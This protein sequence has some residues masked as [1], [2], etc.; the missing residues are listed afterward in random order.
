LVKCLAKA[1]ALRPALKGD[2]RLMLLVDGLGGV[3]QAGV[4][5]DSTRDGVMRE[6]GLTS[7]Y[8][9]DFDRHGEVLCRAELQASL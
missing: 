2:V 1:Q 3:Y 5:P 4:T 8:G 7:V 6:C 9:T